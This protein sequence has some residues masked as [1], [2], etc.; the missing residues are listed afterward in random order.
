MENRKNTVLLTVI[1]VATLLVAVVGAT[2][3]FFAVQ[4][5]ATATKTITVQT[6]TTD[7]TTFTIDSNL[8]IEADQDNFGENAGNQYAHANAS[9]AFVAANQA[10]EGLC[11][12]FTLNV[13]STTFGYSALN[14]E[15]NGSCTDDTK[16]T[17]TACEAASG[18]WTAAPL[19]EL[20]LSVVKGGEFNQDNTAITGGTALVNNL[21]ITT[22]A[23]GTYYIGTTAN[24]GLS[25]TE[26]K[27]ELTETTTEEYQVLLTFVNLATDQTDKAGEA[28]EG[29][30][31]LTKVACAAAQ[32]GGNEQP[33][34]PEP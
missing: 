30:L 26:V 23:A 29:T 18:T 8:A 4:G 11:Y 13:S 33:E 21:D 14:T 10:S 34:T 24:S 6:Y 12:D 27:H 2:F 25:T 17:K 32:Q 3:A 1:A 31:V 15:N 22:L 19:A 16:T 7:S 5:G 9:V 20:T 28:F